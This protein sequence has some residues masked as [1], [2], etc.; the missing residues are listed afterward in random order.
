MENKDFKQGD[1]VF[2]N[3]NPTK[4]HEQAGVR[5]AVVISNEDYHR[6]MGLN[7]VCPITNNTKPFPSHVLLDNRT[8]ITGSIL[9]EHV[10]T[11]DLKERNT[12]FKEKLPKDLLDEVLD[13]VKSCL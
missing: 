4:G 1:I 7:I 11:V 12:V 8:N 6:I 2:M 10:R 5:P 9:C 13:I 3:F